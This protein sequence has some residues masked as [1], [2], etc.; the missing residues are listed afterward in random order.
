MDVFFILLIILVTL[1]LVNSKF[2][3]FV[4]KLFTFKKSSSSS[5]KKEPKTGNYKNASDY[6]D[7]KNKYKKTTSEKN[8]YDEDFDDYV[9]EKA[10]AHEE[11]YYRN[12]YDKY[13][14]GGFDKKT[15]SYDAFLKKA[16]T[17]IK[18]DFASNPYNDKFIT[19]EYGTILGFMFE[20][21]KTVKLK[22]NLSFEYG[23][24]GQKLNQS[25]VFQIVEFFKV[26]T[27][28]STNRKG[29]HKS[30]SGSQS[31][32]YGS[33]YYGSSYSTSSGVKYTPEQIKNQEM[34]TKLKAVHDR[35][36]EQLNKMKSTDPERPALVNEVN[37]VKRKMKVFY[38]KSGLKKS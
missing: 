5:S 2:N 28:L 1:F 7:A 3:A 35:R 26:L 8:K 25:D 36:M 18:N 10:K 20:N 30:W 17:D 32:S 27:S 31:N 12:N 23:N 19:S 37:V 16:L 11:T 22:D 13:T 29:G 6:A 33:G 9:Y 24:E 15:S 21:G 38:E 4:K 34:F 14:R